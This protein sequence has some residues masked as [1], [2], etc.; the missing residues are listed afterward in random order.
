[1]EQDVDGD[2][3]TLQILLHGF[4]CASGNQGS[5]IVD[6]GTDYDCVKHGD[7]LFII[8]SVDRLDCSAYDR[9]FFCFRGL[10]LS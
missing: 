1:M 3:N 9:L 2:A 4:C 8:S 7:G 10:R 6:W 5:H